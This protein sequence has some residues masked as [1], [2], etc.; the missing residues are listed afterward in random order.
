MMHFHAQRYRGWTKGVGEKEGGHGSKG[1][2]RDRAK[3]TG[4]G[5]SKQAQWRANVYSFVPTTNKQI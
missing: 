3:Q 4:T 5:Q 2:Y 1:G